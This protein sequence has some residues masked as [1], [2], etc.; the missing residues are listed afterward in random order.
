MGSLDALVVRFEMVV[1]DLEH[2]EDA[3]AAEAA[4]WFQWEV[5][6]ARAASL[7]TRDTARLLTEDAQMLCEDLW[8]R[9][10]VA[11]SNDPSTRE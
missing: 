11:D 8:A 9:E 6:K 2:G 5:V 7:L 4:Q 3:N 1:Q 10:R